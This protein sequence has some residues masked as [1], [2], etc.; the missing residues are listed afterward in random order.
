MKPTKVND[1][2]KEILEL[3]D[4]TDAR[5]DEKIVACKSAGDLLNQ[6]MVMET[7]IVAVQE[8]LKNT[9]GNQ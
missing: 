4:K 5:I 2:A 9:F 1:L 8:S 3:L 7:T 6:V